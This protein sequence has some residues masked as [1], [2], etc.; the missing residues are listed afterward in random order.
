MQTSMPGWLSETLPAP[1]RTRAPSTS[2]ALR[3]GRPPLLPEERGQQPPRAQ[4][5]PRSEHTTSCPLLREAN[6]LY[7]PTSTLYTD[8]RTVKPSLG[9]THADQ[10]NITTH[11]SN[12]L[13]RENGSVCEGEADFI[14]MR[15]RHR[16]KPDSF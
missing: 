14:K 16:F 5:P 8:V 2:S 9:G 4:C 13:L 12:F 7:T 10:P 1:C 6:C 3:R 15:I 11:V